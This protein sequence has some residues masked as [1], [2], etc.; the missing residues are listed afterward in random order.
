MPHLPH[1]TPRELGLDERR[2]QAAYARLAEWTTGEEPVWPAAAVLIGREG[3]TLP[4]HFAGRQG[5][6]S[7]APPLRRDG[8]FLLASITKPLTY[9]AGLMLVERGLLNLSDLVTRYIPEFAAHHKEATRVAH[10]FTHTSGLPDMLENNQQLRREHA[11][12]SRFIEGAIRDTVPLFAPGTGFS[13]QSMGTL[14]VAELVQRLTGRS[15]AE[16]LEREI[17]EPLGMYDSALGRRALPRERLVPVRTQ[18]AEATDWDWN[19]EY[20]QEF[21]AP[22]GGMYSSP[23]DLAIIADLMLNGGQH[24]EVR[25]LSP[26]LTKRMCTN[27]L[28]DFPDVPEPLRRTKA[29]GLGWQMNHPAGDDSLCDLRSEHTFGHLGATGT[30]LWMDPEQ[31]SF[32]LILTNAPR[33]SGPWRLVQ[34]SNMLAA[35]L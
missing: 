15:I 32:C 28:H 12:L 25:L 2:L 6:E 7:A 22:W 33:D 18:A 13:Y 11:P 26:A 14:I 3:R 17:F 1:A 8:L 10:L 27:R 5:T 30:L 29:W 23:E 35:A 21:G 19:S 24:G 16:F 34:L 4:P 31:T 9:L 20:W